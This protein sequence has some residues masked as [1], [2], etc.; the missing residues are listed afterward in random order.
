MASRHNQQKRNRLFNTQFMTS[1]ISTTLVLVLLGTIVMF[2]L[3]AKNL[4]AFIK[5]NLNVSVLLNE[6][7][8]QPEIDSLKE[9]LTCCPYVKSLV[10]VSKEQ[11]LEETSQELGTD[12][13]E[14]LGYNPFTP[15]FEIKVN[16]I[17]ANNDSLT[18]IVARLDQLEEVV[19]VD[20]DKETIESVNDNIRK[21]SVVLL[22]IAGLFLYISFALINNTVRLTIFSKRFLINTMKLVGASWG[23][24]RRPFLKNA[25]MLG[26]ISGIVADI[27]L[28]IGINWMKVYE[29]GLSTIL[30]SGITYIVCSSVI[31]CGLLITFLCTYASLG[32][33]LKMSSNELYNI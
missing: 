25:F 33:Y 4:S 2:V 5:E 8:K 9:Q 31:V 16:E 10:F 18:K 12:P 17:Y 28:I 32:R 20:Y 26:V 30:T 6:E 22:V 23:F 7:L 13:S 21:I 1:C 14:F 11:A 3:S 24:I 15:S 19:G 29:P 27:L